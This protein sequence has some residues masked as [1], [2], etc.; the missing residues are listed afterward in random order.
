MHL[1]TK[2]TEV[3]ASPRYHSQRVPPASFA[4]VLVGLF[5]SLSAAQFPGSLH[6]P[7]DIVSAAAT[8]PADVVAVTEVTP[9]LTD[10][11]LARVASLP[12]KR[13]NKRLA[14]LSDPHPLDNHLLDAKTNLENIRQQLRHYTCVLVR[15][16]RLN[17]EL[18]PQEFIS[19]KI[20]N[21]RIVNGQLEVPFSVYMKFL[22][23]SD[24][25]G[26]EVV[27]VE[28][29]NGD[30]MLAHEGGMKR[31]FLPS[32]WLKPDGTIVMRQNRYP[33]TEVGIENLA[34]RILD[35]GT[36]GR[37]AGGTCLVK[38]T[39]DSKVNGRV[40]TCVE[41]TVSPDNRAFGAH[42]MQVFTDDELQI[43]IRY[44]AYDWPTDDG[45]CG[46]I[47]EQY[48]YVKLKSN[49]GLTDE[50][51]NHKNPQYDF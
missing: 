29:E 28:G 24:V 34:F 48:T 19:L 49:I 14:S 27:Y 6:L 17:G 2:K 23:P 20:R 38:R 3:P 1:S 46:D 11:P 13:T 21:R 26:R 7:N 4:V 9:A 30:K 47:L 42:R 25:R 18:K 35:R 43:P 12:E 33:L 31:H 22:K 37:N 10:E 32:V 16:E 36:A 39:P 45:G 41:V 50:D 8:V 40:C 15:Q 51:F 5:S 44:V